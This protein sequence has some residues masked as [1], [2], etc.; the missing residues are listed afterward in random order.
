ML[1]HN[2]NPLLKRY[3]DLVP[4]DGFYSATDVGIVWTRHPETDLVTD[5]T[6]QFIPR[7]ARK[8]M[9]AERHSSWR[10]EWSNYDHQWKCS[11][12]NSEKDW[13]DGTDPRATPAGLFGSWLFRG[14][15]NKA[16]EARALHELSRIKECDWARAMLAAR[17][18]NSVD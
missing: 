12:G 14:F 7:I 2:S 17:R 18:L 15:H 4:P 3:A 8:H 13:C 10:Q 6:V 16:E 1:D 11:G 9:V 5:V